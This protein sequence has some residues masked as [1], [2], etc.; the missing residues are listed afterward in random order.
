MRQFIAIG[1]LLCMSAGTLYPQNSPTRSAAEQE[2]LKVNQARL[3]AF[4][5]RDVATWTRYVADDCIF[6]DD[7]GALA[8]KADMVEGFQLP[9][10]YEYGTNNR[11]SVVHVYGTSAVINFRAT[12]HEL[13]GGADI[14]SEQRYTVT[15]I[16]QSGT[17]L[18][19]A[20]HWGNLPVNYRKSVAANPAAYKDY[21]G[22]YERWRPLD[23][24]ETVSAKDGRLWTQ[25]GKKMEEL[26]PAGGDTFFLK[27][28][29][30]GTTTF[31]RDSQGHV[32][33]YIYRRPDGQ[34]IHIKKL[35]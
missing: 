4:N 25:W 17:W 18:L 33:G 31:M 5:K 20:E 29:S 28:G 30:L 22:V 10:E 19:V 11:V 15:Y 32:T 26:L 16:K 23:D 9:R 1:A 8:T 6:S 21:V 3:D 2:V 12:V 34:E 24:S 7:D 35:K 27:N 13:L 14:V